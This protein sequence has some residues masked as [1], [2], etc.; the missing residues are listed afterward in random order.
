MSAITFDYE[1]ILGSSGNGNDSMIVIYNIAGSEDYS[2]ILDG[3]P[4]NSKIKI[5]DLTDGNHIFKLIDNQNNQVLSDEISININSNQNYLNESYS[6]NDNFKSIDIFIGD[7]IEIKRYPIE[8][9]VYKDLKVNSNIIHEFET[10][11]FKL[12]L[13]EAINPASMETNFSNTTGGYLYNAYEGLSE[14]D[15]ISCITYGCE[16]I[17][18]NE[19]NKK[20]IPVISTG[21]YT[22]NNRSQK[23]YSNFS[24][25][26]IF[27]KDS[28]SYTTLDSVYNEQITIYKRDENFNNIPFI[29]YKEDENLELE[30]S[31]KKILENNNTTIQ[32]STSSIGN[33][34]SFD[35]IYNSLD[36][37]NKK[38]YLESLSEKKG[39]GN[40][41]KRILYTDFFPIKNVKVFCYDSLNPNQIDVINPNLLKINEYKGFIYIN[42]TTSKTKFYYVFYDIVPR[43][44]YEYKNE[45]E[46]LIRS[47]F[48]LDLRQINNQN[49]TGLI[50]INY[51]EKNIKK[52]VLNQEGR[53]G[54]TPEF[55]PQC[56]IGVDSLI[57]NAKVLNANNSPV[58]EIPVKFKIQSLPNDNGEN[59]YLNDSTYIDGISD[60]SNSDGIS[61]CIYF[62]PYREN[63]LEREIESIVDDLI[64]I[65]SNERE[66]NNLNIFD[67]ETALYYIREI[68]KLDSF[69][70]YTN[71]KDYVIFY[72][73]D[74]VSQKCKPVTPSSIYSETSN[75]QIKIRY[76]KNFG[77]N[78]L[79]EQLKLYAPKYIK[80]VAEAIDPATGQLITSNDCYIKLKF[81]NYLKGS[82]LS[83]SE[84]QYLGYGFPPQN[85]ELGTGLGG[86][87]YFTIN[88]N[89]VYSK[90]AKTIT[91]FNEQQ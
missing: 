40:G 63:S 47:N 55:E 8:F 84:M 54:E 82:I 6:V 64:V 75:S 2:I 91:V 56:D 16:F 15:Y 59:G 33:L 72:E 12:D 1:I 34:R 48:D 74:Q 45:E 19:S 67:K 36:L 23:F 39:Y 29:L 86:M 60:L 76:S 87:N 31:Y 44:D 21:E 20:F 68:E 73:Y 26:K 41:F 81:P 49:Q 83:N 5:S 78:V 58:E 88:P 22:I 27:E 89:D 4:I 53:L 79:K 65:K 32:I 77:G 69:D 30:F 80:I 71:D 13:T 7:S 85:N 28:F 70:F 50:C 35:T 24:I 25:T 10:S 43:L 61:R 18:V 62:A 52:I 9:Y 3:N 37:E 42:E 90:M 66:M 38:K 57:L 51:E 11:G 46:D 17:S 14:E